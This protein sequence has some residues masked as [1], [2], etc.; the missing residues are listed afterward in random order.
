MSR[1][2]KWWQLVER[3][4]VVSKR[5]LS[6]PLI[7]SFSHPFLG[8][9]RHANS[10]YPSYIPSMRTSHYLRNTLMGCSPLRAHSCPGSNV[11]SLGYGSKR[12]ISLGAGG[13]G[14][15]KTHAQAS[16]QFDFAACAAV[17]RSADTRRARRAMSGRVG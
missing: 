15:N 2:T 10:Q 5:I 11:Y 17:A 16:P 3:I 6:T 1:R 13:K 9:T 8:H 14:F 12:Y 4:V 7:S